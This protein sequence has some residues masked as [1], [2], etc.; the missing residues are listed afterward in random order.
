MPNNHVRRKQIR[1][2]SDEYSAP[3]NVCSITL[4]TAHRL[5]EF[6]NVAL[7]EECELALKRRIDAAGVTLL[8]YCLMPDHAHLLLSPSSGTSMLDFVRDYKGE[9][10]HLAWRYG[11]RGALWQRSFYDHFLRK[12]EDM[13]RVVAYILDNPLRAGLVQE[14]AMYRF[15]GSFLGRI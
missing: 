15:S 6:A 3:G 5:P 12:D 2:P 4:T 10:T 13:Y 8:A 7:A 1:L 9:T 11:V 14:P